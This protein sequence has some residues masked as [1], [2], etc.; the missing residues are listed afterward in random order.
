MN[1]P[2]RR[3]FVSLGLALSFVV[4][5]GCSGSN[6]SMLPAGHTGAA[7]HGRVLRAP[8]GPH[9]IVPNAAGSASRALCD[10]TNDPGHASCFARVRMASSSQASVGGLQPNDLSNIYNY[11]LPS[12]QGQTSQVIGIVIAGGAPNAPSDLA[13]YRAQF[14]LGACTTASGCLTVVSAA[15][16]SAQ[17]A[18]RDPDSISPHPTYGGPDENAPAAE[19]SPSANEDS[20]DSALRGP[21]SISPHPTTVAGGWPDEADI[22]LEAASAVC[23][24]CQLLLVQAASDSLAD[25]GAAVTQAQQNGA[26]IVNASFGAPESSSDTN[27]TSAYAPSG[28][29][30]VAAAGDNGPGLYFPASARKSIAVSGTTV[31][32]SGNNVSETLWSGSGGGCSSVF[33]APNFETNYCNGM[34]T[35]ADVAAVA[36][37]NTGIAFYDSNLGGWGIAGGTSVAAPIIAGMWALQ[38]NMQS[39]WGA[40]PLWYDQNA[41]YQVQ[42]AGALDGVGTPN[43]TS[44][45]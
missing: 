38:G 6:V 3:H 30:V 29:K 21:E 19:S 34:R 33:S 39:G 45:L 43:G 2:M 20:T 18:E 10:T 24:N 16:A 31:N 36:D 32:I 13:V 22:D 8:L 17:S 5:G 40:S 1:Q 42:N 15:S 12:Q 37:P 35:V 23:S 4:L 9:S 25:L 7:S 28:V 27:Y 26:T 44:G 41:F 14:G 11:T